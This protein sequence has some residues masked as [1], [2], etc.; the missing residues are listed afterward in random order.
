M[1]AGISGTRFVSLE[2]QNHVILPNEP[3]FARFPEEAR[4]FLS[5]DV[6]QC[7]CPALTLRVCDKARFTIKS[8][9][10]A[11][12][13]IGHRIEGYLETLLNQSFPDR[14]ASGG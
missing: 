6:R 9:D 13:L 10:T 5:V 8:R 4:S 14:A 1:A 12:G 3:A 2:G 11:I 7:R